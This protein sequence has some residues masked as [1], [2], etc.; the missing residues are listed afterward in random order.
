MRRFNEGVY[1]AG[2]SAFERKLANRFGLHKLY[3]YELR[4]RFGLPGSDGL[5]G[6]GP[7]SGRP[8]S[9]THPSK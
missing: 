6:I 4:E 1:L 5:S 8:T 9:G 7:C 3:Y 2:C